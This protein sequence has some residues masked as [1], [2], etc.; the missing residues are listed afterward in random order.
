[1]KFL[2]PALALVGDTVALRPPDAG[3]PAQRWT[4][5]AKATIPR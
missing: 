1:M 4:L 3:V 2:A 5:A